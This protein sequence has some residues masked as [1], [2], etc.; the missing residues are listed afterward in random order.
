MQIKT[1]N[2]QLLK[3]T[4]TKLNKENK[5]KTLQIL[6]KKGHRPDGQDT[7]MDE[8]IVSCREQDSFDNKRTNTK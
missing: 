5:T 6:R 7:S 8:A 3:Q 4:G 1:L 2:N